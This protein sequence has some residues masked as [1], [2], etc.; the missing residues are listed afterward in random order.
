MFSLTL[1][2]RR[3][4]GSSM[5]LLLAPADVRIRR[6]AGSCPKAA[7]EIPFP[8]GPGKGRDRDLKENLPCKR[9]ES[10]G[11]GVPAG[12]GLLSKL[13]EKSRENEK[14][15]FLL[16][17]I[18]NPTEEIREQLSKLSRERG[19]KLISLLDGIPEAFEKKQE[20][21]NLPNTMENLQ[22]EDWL[23]YLSHCDALVTDSGTAVPLP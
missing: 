3:K 22:V 8:V 13:A 18:L 23:Y 5:L 12:S 2:R 11:S 20:N 10:V 19:Q 17:Y 21:L 16:A 1:P 15:P 6:G 14:E 4:S 9:N 7:E